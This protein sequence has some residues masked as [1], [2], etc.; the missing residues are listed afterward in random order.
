MQYALAH[1]SSRFLRVTCLC[2][3][4]IIWKRKQ[5]K[6]TANHFNRSK[7]R[8]PSWY[9]VPLFWQPSDNNV[10]KWI[11]LQEIYIYERRCEDGIVKEDK[12]ISKNEK[13]KQSIRKNFKVMLGGKKPIVNLFFVLVQVF[14]LF[15]LTYL[16]KTFFSLLQLRM[17]L[18]LLRNCFFKAIKAT[19]RVKMF[20]RHLPCF[21][22]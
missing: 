10:E 17:C 15:I 19:V 7:W 5:Q 13:K 16:L 9:P 2:W 22:L 6:H 8:M 14:L 4:R 3:T 21:L 18:T 1:C 11:N 12:R 20:Q